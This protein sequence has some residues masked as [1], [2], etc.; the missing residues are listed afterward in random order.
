MM[1]Q[2]LFPS[3][4]QPLTR[5]DG[6]SITTQFWTVNQAIYDEHPG[7]SPMLSTIL[8][9]GF[10]ITAVISAEDDVK[11]GSPGFDKCLACVFR[12]FEGDRR[13]N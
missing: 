6:A 4:S 13:Q 11:I 1:S 8:C 7:D 5:A 12:D 3:N 2:V 10:G 9:R